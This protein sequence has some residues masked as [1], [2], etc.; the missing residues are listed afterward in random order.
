MDVMFWVWLGVIVVSAII[1][2]STMEIV[3]IWFTFG[4]II[5]FIMAGTN[6]VRWEIQL[7]VFVV[8]SAI[9]IVSLRG[10]TKKFLLR[11]SNEKTNV[12]SL[13]GKHFRMLERTDFETLGSLKINDIIWSAIGENQQVIEKGDV[14]E[15]VKIEGNKLTVRKVVE[16]NAGYKV[17]QVKNESVAK[18]KKSTKSTAKK[19]VASDSVVEDKKIDTEKKTSKKEIK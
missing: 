18:V 16:D 17:E 6:A 19:K 8:V 14:V 15:I 4:A 13:I 1:E 9:L 12:D 3:S 10:I 5:P 11:N 7:V 2:F